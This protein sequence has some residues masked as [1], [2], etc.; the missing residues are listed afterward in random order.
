MNNTS[1]QLKKS[2][3]S[4]ILLVVPW[5]VF[6]V[7]F[8]ILIKLG[9][10]QLSRADIKVQLLQQ[11]QQKQL[12]QPASLAE[13]MASD[14]VQFSPLLLKGKWLKH[15]QF[16]LDNR[17]QNGTTGYNLLSLFADQSG[18]KIL[19]DRGWRALVRNREFNF[20]Q[21]R[22][23]QTTIAGYAFLPNVYDVVDVPNPKS[24]EVVIVPGLNMPQFRQFFKLQDIEIAPFIMRQN[25]PEMEHGL[26][27][28]WTIITFPPERHLGYAL[29]WFSLALAL[30]LIPV[31]IYARRRKVSRKS[32][33]K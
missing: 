26:L 18:T 12:Q 31:F 3:P 14:D 23:N 4:K 5:V 13:L 27:R 33:S 30:A 8:S 28:Q 21:P 7:V 25:F 1:P 22:Q 16:I 32:S 9:L 19:V 15:W 20:T 11:R 10:W 29:Q 2:I 24:S 17:I 6:V